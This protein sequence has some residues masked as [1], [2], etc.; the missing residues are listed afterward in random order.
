VPSVRRN[1]QALNRM[2]WCA[3]SYGTGP[4]SFR[5]QPIC[6]VPSTIRPST[7]RQVKRDMSRVADRS[8]SR[9]VSQQ[10]WRIRLEAHEQEGDKK[11]V[12]T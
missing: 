7:R 5:Y 8:G 6:R 12:I 11:K 2:S 10:I 4:L 1:I 3:K 9:F